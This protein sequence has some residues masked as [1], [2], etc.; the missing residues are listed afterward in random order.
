[1]EKDLLGNVN[2]WKKKRK[3]SRGKRPREKTAN[4]ECRGKASPA[5]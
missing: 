1:M 4:K 5:S 2:E 3:G